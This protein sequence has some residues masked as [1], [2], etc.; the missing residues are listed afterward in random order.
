[1]KRII[2]T[3]LSVLLAVCLFAGCAE[4][5]GT[6]G[7]DLPVLRVGVFQ[8]AT[9]PNGAGGRQET[10][11]TQFAHYQQPTVVVGGVEYQVELVI[12]DN[13]TT[14]ATSP[15][16]AQNLVAQDV[17]IVLG[18]YGSAAA[19]AASDIFRDAGLTAIGASCTNPGVTRGNDHY[20]RIC[21]LD[22]FQGQILA[23][24]AKN[25]FE[26][27]TAYVLAL[28]GDDYS[29]GLANFFMESFT[30]YGGEVIYE[31]FPAG[32]S[33]FST[34][35]LN[36]KASNADIW[37]SPTST[38]AAA[39]IIDAAGAQDIGMP[40]LAGDTWDSNVVTGAAQGKDVRIYVTTFYQEG[41]APEFDSG[42]QAW[43]NANPIHL[44]NNGGNDRVAGVTAM[45]YDVYFVGLDILQ[46]AGS[47]TDQAAIRAATWATSF[48]GPVTGLIEFDE[49]GDA[50]RDTAFV[51]VVNTE[52][53][54]WEFFARQGL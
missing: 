42:I 45:G 34:Y 13:Q 39:L 54:E 49:N 4:T 7:S 26:A 10:L 21:F 14:P 5:G 52:T 1:M 31:T 28:Q 12:V 40:I 8:P 9:G 11:G 19:M 32:T 20:F 15:A 16:A 41:G 2:P 35:V 36:A 33:D 53:G 46:R 18:T 25:H 38:E 22:P 50:A 6:A 43:M 23:S 29:V 48:M 51:K 17:A 27:Q 3:V 24:L 30:A 37:F 47:V 44:A